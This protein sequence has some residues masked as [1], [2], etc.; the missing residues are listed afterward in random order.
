MSR[1]ELPIEGMTCNLWFDPIGGG[2]GS[3]CQPG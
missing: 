3:A 2:L 1:I